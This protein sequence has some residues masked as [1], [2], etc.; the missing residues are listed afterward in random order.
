MGEHAKER[1]RHTASENTSESWRR[2]VGVMLEDYTMKRGMVFGGILVVALAAFEIF[3]F[4]TTEFALTD[5]LGDERFMGIRWATILA[6]AFCGIDFAGLARLFTPEQGRGEATEVW[7]LIGAWFLGA[8]LNAIATWWAVTLA[9][10]HRNIG[11]EVLSRDDLLTY[12]PV[13]VAA[14]VW[15]TRILLIGTFSVAGERLFTQA[16]RILRES[17]ARDAATPPQPAVPRAAAHIIGEAG[18]STAIRREGPA[19]PAAPG[20]TARPLQPLGLYTRPAPKPSQRDAG[21]LTAD[22]V[23]ARDEPID[24]DALPPF[25]RTSYAPRP[26]NGHN[27][28]KR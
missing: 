21:Q 14:I 24:D 1:N 16:E 28:A 3:N 17:R 18:A 7:Y 26:G 23:A 8:T 15:L 4:G 5:F 2:V 9:L 6:T 10:L 11:N 20:L 12:V 13:F 25:L 22:R 27:G 19:R